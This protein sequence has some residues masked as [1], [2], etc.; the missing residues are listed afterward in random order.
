MI[1]YIVLVRYLY[2]YHVN[3]FCEPAVDC[4][5]TAQS[6]QGLHPDSLAH[7]EDAINEQS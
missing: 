6:S 1:T 3:Q 7:S 4:Y 5:T 2:T